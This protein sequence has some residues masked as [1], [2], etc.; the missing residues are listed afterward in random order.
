MGQCGGEIFPRRERQPRPGIGHHRHHTL[1]RW[2]TLGVQGNRVAARR[3]VNMGCEVAAK[4]VVL[5]GGVAEIHVAQNSSPIHA[6]ERPARS[7]A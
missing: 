1:L 6:H 2:L 5:A 3:I 4:R 7:A